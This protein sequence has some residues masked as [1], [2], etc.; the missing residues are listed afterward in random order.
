MKSPT[1]CLNEVLLRACIRAERVNQDRLA[2]GD[3]QQL[4]KRNDNDASFF[5]H[6]SRETIVSRRVIEP[7]TESAHER[8]CTGR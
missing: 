2:D 3:A 5:R 4:A 6:I 8:T 7:R 1:A